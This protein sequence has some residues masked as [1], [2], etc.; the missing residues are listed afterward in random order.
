MHDR[1]LQIC[2]LVELA[3]GFMVH[4]GVLCGVDFMSHFKPNLLSL[5]LK[6]SQIDFVPKLNRG[7]GDLAHRD[8][9]PDTKG[10]LSMPA[11]YIKW[12]VVHLHKT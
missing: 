3:T 6:F 11:T 2:K 7:K 1:P 8:K 4:G 9:T 10:R 5:F 12:L